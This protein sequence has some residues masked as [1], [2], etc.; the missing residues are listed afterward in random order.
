MVNSRRVTGMVLAGGR[1]RRMGRDKALLEIGGRNLLG[2][3]VD[4]LGSLQL[5]QVVVSGD[6]PGYDCLADHYPQLGPLAGL[7]AGCVRFGGVP[8]ACQ[9]ILLLPVDM[10]LMEAGPLRR[11]LL[12]PAG[13]YYRRAMLPA[14]VPLTG[15][16]LE[17]LEARLGGR[18]GNRSVGRL[19]DELGLPELAIP[20]SEQRLFSN[21][22]TP[23]EWQACIT[24]LS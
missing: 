5:S 11:L 12:Q 4:L 20:P 21:S 7:H 3:A 17:R 19:F 8:A 16:L 22:N 10:P 6:Y 15:G 9:G 18:D 1:S 2:R 13:G 24:A 23:D 14:L